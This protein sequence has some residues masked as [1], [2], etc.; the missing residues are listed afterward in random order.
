M[1]TIFQTLFRLPLR[2][3]SHSSQDPILPIP[4]SIEKVEEMLLAEFDN[5]AY[6]SLLFTGLNR[7]EVQKRQSDD[8]KALRVIESTRIPD[9]SIPDDSLKSETVT[10]KSGNLRL[11]KCLIVTMDVNIP[12]T[13]K[14]ELADKYDMHHL[15]PM[16]IAATLDSDLVQKSKYNLFCALPLPIT[17]NIPAHISAPLILE[18]E[19]RNIR[20]NS[21]RTGIES[22][23]N[24]WL[25]L[26]EIP[27]LYLGLLERLLQVQG[28]NILWW[29][30]TQTRDANVP[31]QI[32]MNAFWTSDILKNTP[33]R[34]FASEYHRASFLNPNE[35]MLYSKTAD[36]FSGFNSSL[37]KVLSF[38][39]PS[40]IS[41]LPSHLFKYAMKA[42]LRSLDAAFVRTLLE[43]TEPPN[44]WMSMHEINT[45]LWYLSRHAVSLDGLSLIPLEDGSWAKIQVSYNKSN[46]VVGPKQI[47]AY[48]IFPANRLV[49]RDFDVPEGL[50]KL[51]V[52]VSRLGE[53]GMVEF[54][55][56]RIKPASE[57]LGAEADRVWIASFWDAKLDIA[58]KMISHIPL[59]P[60][61]NPHYFISMRS[62]SELS[63]SIVDAETSGEDFDY[64]IL[65]KLGMII[66]LRKYASLISEVKGELTIYE[67]FLEYMQKDEAK[68]LK[69]ISSLRSSDHE[70]LGHWVRLKF[71]STPPSLANI[72]C[73]LPVW[74][75]QQRAKSPHLGALNDAIVLP[76]S[77]PSHILLPFTDY[78]IISWEIGMQSVK[79]EG[80]NAKDITE[81]L[82]ISHGT[83]LYSPAHEVEYKQFL[84]CFLHLERV[85][86]Y[87][88]LVPNEEGVLSPAESLFERHEL[89]LAALGV[90]PE[91]LLHSGFQDVAE[92]LGKYDLN[93]TH[94]LNLSMFIECANAF[95][96]YD[97][98]DT[99]DDE[100][101]DKEGDDVDD[102][103]DDGDEEG[104]EDRPEDDD[105]EN[106]FL[107]CASAIS[108]GGVAGEGEDEND[109]DEDSDEEGDEDSEDRP[110]DGNKRRRSEVLYEYFNKLSLN[111]NDVDLCRELD[112]LKFIPRGSANR[113]GYEG[114]NIRKY[115][116]RHILSP[117]KIA[118][119]DY[120]AICWS[121]RGSVEPQPNPTLR[122]TYRN[123]G[124]PTGKEVASTILLFVA[125]GS[126]LFLK[127][128][129]HLR[130][131]TELGKKHDRHP[132][133]LSDLKATYKWLNENAEKSL[134]VIKNEN[135]KPVFFNVDNPDS[136]P[137]VWHSASTLINDSQDIG[138]MHGV[139]G[140]LRNYA[141]LMK[142][143]GV[144]MIHG[145]AADSQPEK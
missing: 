108:D 82:C 32:F 33:R 126:H 57:F 103:D 15:L 8:F 72:A 41:E 142:A 130:A 60:T 104:S 125:I 95:D 123:L 55:E 145:A 23:Y 43:H 109:D 137:W 122:G 107:E 64:G 11:P 139:K 102:E 6:K 124:K 118:L 92:P 121:Q 28:T 94:R 74:S 62:I 106:M 68:G 65:Q 87:S 79:K 44:Q 105:D 40:N 63:V 90:T 115:M 39:R 3:E 38:T 116:Q 127:K 4:W 71:S 129:K 131:L 78:P 128:V 113:K 58:P 99:G 46:Y 69:E 76:V 35:V 13:F 54:L 67:S 45:L 50:L 112:Q 22:Q 49:H 100:S 66:I 141:N 26:S 140:F 135:Q 83:I 30:G 120:E 36:I 17:T 10:F 21:D 14:A 1:L 9:V 53:A 59:I 91:R 42:Q 143:A 34:V 47:T 86:G 80:C 110:D 2:N 51:G 84:T 117:S 81:L 101:E 93:L 73:K 96:E 52:N 144:R 27:R 19:R 119:A 16:R 70:E 97:D 98:E 61:L 31:S 24:L 134:A 88:L 77:M 114:M 25:L 7:I 75:I 133:L 111:P 138:D 56:E 20:I 37:S 48:T 132:A 12:D 136:D 29:P 89:F 85:A 18:Q 5:V